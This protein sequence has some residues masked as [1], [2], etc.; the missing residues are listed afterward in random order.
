MNR[1]RSRFAVVALLV[2]SLLV[3]LQGGGGSPTTARAQGASCDLYGPGEGTGEWAIPEVGSMGG[4]GSFRVDS[5]FQTPEDPN[6]GVSQVLAQVTLLP[7]GE[8]SVLSDGFSI[9]RVDSGSVR[10]WN[11]GSTPIDIV[12]GVEPKTVEP[13]GDG[14]IDAN[15]AIIV[16]NTDIYYLTYESAGGETPTPEAFQFEQMG[17]GGSKALVPTSFQPGDGA[18]VS[19]GMVKPTKLCARGSC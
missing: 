6:T 14:V 7:E 9:I 13:A 17:F 11:C 18:K 8:L 19:A 10:L 12:G 15:E 16:A 1:R 3:A 2:L 5:L 4:E